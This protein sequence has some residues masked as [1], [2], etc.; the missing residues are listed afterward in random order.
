[1]SGIRNTAEKVIFCN[2]QYCSMSAYPDL[3]MGTGTGGAV[4]P[5][6]VA[7]LPALVAQL[8]ALVAQYTGTGGAVCKGATPSVEQ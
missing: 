4:I 3:H 7:Q 6:L 1:M 5:A 8:P 2:G